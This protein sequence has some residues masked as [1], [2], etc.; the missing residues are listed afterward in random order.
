MQ[1]F[2]T[3]S[4]GLPHC[5]QISENQK[6]QRVVSFDFDAFFATLQMMGIFIPYVEDQK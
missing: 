1:P 4:F 2:L 6:I 3:E 5:E